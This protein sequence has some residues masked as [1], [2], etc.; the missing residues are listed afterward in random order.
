M[1]EDEDII[2]VSPFRDTAIRLLGS[3]SITDTER[4]KLVYTDD[5]DELAA[6]AEE[7]DELNQTV[8]I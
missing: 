6:F 2:A 3:D 1:Y 5:E 7:A 8:W 4:R